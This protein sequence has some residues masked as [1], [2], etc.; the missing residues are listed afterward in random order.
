MV[1]VKY[2]PQERFQDSEYWFNKFLAL[3]PWEICEF[4][5]LV[6]DNNDPVFGELHFHIGI[7]RALSEHGFFNLY[8]ND[9]DHQA[10]LDTAEDVAN[11]IRELFPEQKEALEK[12]NL[13]FSAMKEHGHRW[14]WPTASFNALSFDDQK[15]NKMISKRIIGYS[16]IKTND[17]AHLV[18][19]RIESITN[20][21][22]NPTLKEGFGDINSGTI[23]FVIDGINCR[24]TQISS[25]SLELSVN[26]FEFNKSILNSVNDRLKKLYDSLYDDRYEF[27]YF[28]RHKSEN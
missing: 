7:Q 22:E 20:T 26:T 9:Q 4:V 11:Q 27:E 13:A 1:S 18:L 10:A 15:I 25:N 3:W 14:G 6:G 12:F 28:W 21:N 24:V 16:V 17:H 19:N 5:S 23:Y 8:L 2:S